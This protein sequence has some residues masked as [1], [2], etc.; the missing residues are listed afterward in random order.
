M[1]KNKGKQ[2]FKKKEKKS[3]QTHNPAKEGQFPKN[4]RFITENLISR[5]I[6]RHRKRFLIG[7]TT[8]LILL[9]IATVSLDAYI[10]Y[11]ENKRFTQERIKIEKEIKFWQSAIDRFPNYRDAYF[12]LAILNYRLRKLDVSRKYLDK[13]LKLDPNFKDGRKLEKILR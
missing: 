3:P 6:H 11:Q 1:S 13:A 8:L 7:F 2:F 9:A 10:N 4:F 12:E 5:Y